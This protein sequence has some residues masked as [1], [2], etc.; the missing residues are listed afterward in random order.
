MV[1]KP[2]PLP[3]KS[4]DQ[5]EPYYRSV[6]EAGGGDYLGIQPAPG[7]TSLILFTDRLTKSCLGIPIHDISIN[8]V[9]EKI[10]SSRA[11][12]NAVNHET[13]HNVKSGFHAVP[14]II[15]L[16]VNL[17]LPPSKNT[18]KVSKAY[19]D[20]TLRKWVNRMVKSDEVDVYRQQV[21]I[22][23]EP[24]VRRMPVPFK[25]KKKVWLHCW[26]RKPDNTW[27][28]NNWHQELADAI[29]PVI[30]VNDLYFLLVDQ[31]YELNKADPGVRVTINQLL[32]ERA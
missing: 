6:V 11:K 12:F 23:M 25:P 17:G 21:R 22:A 29:A 28:V 15:E 1:P 30:G 7:Q 14:E 26:W 32:H 20:R 2:P 4:M 8:N 16:K 5:H 19:F 10:A 18:T 31:D 13:L 3:P 24:L 9:R 27:D